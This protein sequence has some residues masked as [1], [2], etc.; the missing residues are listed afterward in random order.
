M[1][2]CLNMS[3]SLF[4]C[5]DCKLYI[6][7]PLCFFLIRSDRLIFFRK[8]LHIYIY[9][10]LCGGS[11]C[12]INHKSFFIRKNLLLVRQSD[13]L[14][15]PNSLCLMVLLLSLQLFLPEIQYIPILLWEQNKS[16]K[17]IIKKN[18]DL[19]QIYINHQLQIR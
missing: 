14:I 10:Y 2:I 12:G 16:L 11:V 19:D 8:I 17:I 1:R 5:D 6:A 7:K 18:I 9:I 13:I 15:I 3:S 4:L